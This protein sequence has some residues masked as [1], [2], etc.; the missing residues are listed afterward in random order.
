MCVIRAISSSVI[1]AKRPA[2]VCC[3]PVVPK[4]SPTRLSY[5]VRPA[6]PPRTVPVP[7]P[8]AVPNAV[9]LAI[10]PKST[11]LWYPRF[12]LSFSSI[13]AMM[14]SCAPP[15]APSYIAPLPAPALAACQPVLPALNA[16]APAWNAL[17]KGIKLMGSRRIA[18]APDDK[19]LSQPLPPSSQNCGALS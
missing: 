16:P 14:P 5:P 10:F 6:I 13:V 7:I 19:A 9:R 4:I 2:S 11:S 17:P 12:F 15:I 1:P 18:P 3:A 8:K